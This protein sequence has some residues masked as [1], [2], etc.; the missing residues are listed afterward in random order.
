[1]SNS[2]RWE[3]D[4]FTLP[5][6]S[7]QRFSMKDTLLRSSINLMA[8]DVLKLR[9]TTP[10]ATLVFFYLFIAGAVYSDK[11]VLPTFYHGN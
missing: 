7:L 1:M 11:L 6:R 2:T 5:A 9:V 4:R 3:E 10:T 8:H